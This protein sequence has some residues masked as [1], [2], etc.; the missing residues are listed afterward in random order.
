[1]FTISPLSVL[2]VHDSNLQGRGRGNPPIDTHQISTTL[3]T[4]P[5][6][7][8]T[9]VVTV[10]LSHLRTSKFFSEQIEKPINFTATSIFFR[11]IFQKMFSIGN[12]THIALQ[13][14]ILRYRKFKK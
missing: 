4:D 5:G 1:M 8:T 12:R 9:S 10:P 6:R 11:S 14:Q 3:I 2:E 7:N 13:I